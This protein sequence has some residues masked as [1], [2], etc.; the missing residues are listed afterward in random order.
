MDYV[1][2]TISFGSTGLQTVYLGFQPKGIEA[3]A[4]QRYAT[5]QNF[6]H[7]SVGAGDDTY[8]RVTST[9]QDGTGGKTL[10]TAGQIVS[11]WERVGGVLT[12]VCAWSIDSFTA[13]DVVI[14]VLK[15]N[16]SYSVFL[17]VWG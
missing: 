5:T 3:T 6:S 10:D 17:R 2:G 16:A 13:T 11:V 15:A 7:I 12:E 8:Q 4:G 1:N 14:N 9:Y